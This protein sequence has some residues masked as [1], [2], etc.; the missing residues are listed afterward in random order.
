LVAALLSYAF[1]PR[2]TKELDI[3][4]LLQIPFSGNVART[5]IPLGITE[6]SFSFYFLDFRQTNL[7][8]AGMDSMFYHTE[9]NAVIPLIDKTE[10]AIV[11]HSDTGSLM[12]T[13]TKKTTKKF[14]I[15]EH[16]TRRP[17]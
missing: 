10:L 11:K 8:T 17:C 12:I 9:I 15:L 1:S 4:P 5:I 7:M 13:N 2:Q 3:V 16:E 14:L 6:F